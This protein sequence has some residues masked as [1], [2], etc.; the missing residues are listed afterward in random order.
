M[1]NL[2]QHAPAL[3]D[4][5]PEIEMIQVALLRQA[6]VTK[7]IRLARSLSQTTMQLFRRAW[8][9]AH[10]DA[11][12]MEVLLTSVTLN[13]GVELAERLRDHL[14]VMG[15]EEISMSQPDILLAL[16]PVVDAFEQLGIDY[17]IGG[18]VASSAHGVP[19]STVDIDL[20]ADL[21]EERVAR[22][23]ERLQDAY[24]VDDQMIRQALAR[25]GSFN[26]IH[27]ATMLKV[28]VFI[29]KARAFDR[30]VAHRTEA[31]AL[32]EGEEARTFYFASSEDV[33]LAKLEWY[34]AGGE[35]SERQWSDVLGVMK[36]QAQTLDFDYLKRWAE[37]LS[38]GD[39]LARALAE[40]AIE[41]H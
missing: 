6:T 41:S 30:E 39:L 38:L 23:V 17:Y 40:A 34:R 5:P 26:L 37:Q 24:Y 22:F 21:H 15:E 3:S 36:V 16:S 33:I 8:R 12:K 28:D 19:R 9:E 20:V 32:D 35:V 11:N 4:T 18:S 14:R 25:R 27:F 1:S 31:H 2:R 7:R 13:Y 29:P 10:A